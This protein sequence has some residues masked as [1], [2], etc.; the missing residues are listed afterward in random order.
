MLSF[1]EWNVWYHSKPHDDNQ[2]KEETVETSPSLLGDIYTF[3]DALVVGCM[4]ITFLK[5]ADRLKI[6]CMAQLVNVIAPILTESGGGVCRQTIFYPFLHTS[7]FGR[8]TALRPIVDSPKYDSKDYT[9]VPYIETVAVMN[10]EDEELTLFVVNRS[11]EDAIT[12]S[13]FFRGFEDYMFTEHI[14][15]ENENLNAVNTLANPDAVVPHIRQGSCVS[16]GKGE[17][18]IE[19]QKTSWN[20]IRFK[21]VKVIDG[22]SV[23]MGINIIISMKVVAGNEDNERCPY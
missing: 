4:L 19:L 7:M 9:D 12:I 6:A 2:M 22:I 23:I 3:E 17:F 1:D 8:G 16:L 11:L 10:E 15:L 20:V 18:T 5:H 14:A 21:R 13:C